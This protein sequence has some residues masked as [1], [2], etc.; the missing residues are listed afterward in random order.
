MRLK[1]RYVQWSIRVQTVAVRLFVH[2][3]PGTH[4]VY[5]VQ[6]LVVVVREAHFETVLTSLRRSTVGARV[7]MIHACCSAFSMVSLKQGRQTHLPPLVLKPGCQ[8]TPHV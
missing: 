2:R 8:L 5:T 3:V 6:T 4:V 1:L 7:D